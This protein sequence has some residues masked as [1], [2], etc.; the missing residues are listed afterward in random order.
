MLGLISDTHDNETATKKAVELFKERN[1]DFIVHCGDIIE[2]EI[3]ELFEGLKIMFVL[4]NNDDEAGLN[5]QAKVLGFDRI[6]EER[7]FVYKNKKFYVYHGTSRAKLEAA[8]KTDKYDYILTGH[9]HVKK[10]EKIGKTNIINPG[11]LSR[12][13]PYTIAFLDAESEELEFAQIKS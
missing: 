7:E 9:T 8:I 3:L 11:A 6:T 13:Y 5:K 2:P 4:G 12:A 1:V 10:H